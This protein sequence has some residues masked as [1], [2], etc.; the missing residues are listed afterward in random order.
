[1][2]EEKSKLVS[3][4]DGAILENVLDITSLMENLRD[5]LQQRQQ[6]VSEILSPIDLSQIATTTKRLKS[7]LLDSNVLNTSLVKKI[8]S[9]QI[10]LSFMPEE[11][12]QKMKGSPIKRENQR[13]DPHYL[14]PDGNIFV[15]QRANPNDP[16]VSELRTCSVYT[17][18]GHLLQEADDVMNIIKNNG[19]QVDA[20]QDDL[21][22][23]TQ[24]ASS[25][26][27]SSIAPTAQIA[28]TVGEQKGANKRAHNT[29]VAPGHR[30]QTNQ[31]QRM[32]QTDI[33]NQGS[34]TAA[35]M[36]TLPALVSVVPTTRIRREIQEVATPARQ[37]SSS[38]PIAQAFTP[39][40]QAMVLVGHTT[41][42]IA[43]H[44]TA[45]AVPVASTFQQLTAP[46]PRANL[47]APEYHYS[48]PSRLHSRYDFGRNYGPSQEDGNPRIIMGIA[49]PVLQWA[50]ERAKVSPITQEAAQ[51][52]GVPCARIGMLTK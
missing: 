20:N 51:A 16:I 37:C 33:N 4:E 41:A 32:S 10:E 18:I 5:T 31:A 35:N 43:L 48:T 15:F 12:R 44:P 17:S 49:V 45:Q 46:A 26:A 14:I 40:T 21:G 36:A 38:I 29:I 13:T 6:K 2:A 30:V 1:M 23:D 52:L 50:K 42:E 3:A 47:A 39:T 9:L 28:T 27:P 19:T 7:A 34:S 25:I 11:M 22:L 24:S 8:N